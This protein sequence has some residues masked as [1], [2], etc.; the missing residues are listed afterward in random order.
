MA[1]HTKVRMDM[2]FSIIDCGARER[3]TFRTMAC[4]MKDQPHGL[5]HGLE[6][7]IDVNVFRK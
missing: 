5:N 4:G 7:G 2:M 6:P 3:F 1:C